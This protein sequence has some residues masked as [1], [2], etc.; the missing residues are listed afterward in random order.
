MNSLSNLI[1]NPNV[2][3]QNDYVPV[4][5]MHNKDL[6]PEVVLPS[7]ELHNKGHDSSLIPVQFEKID[8]CEY[9]QLLIKQT[10]VGPSN[11]SV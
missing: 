2:C 1:F 3:K 4:W 10:G 7:L 6:V 5:P 8:M 9:S 11:L